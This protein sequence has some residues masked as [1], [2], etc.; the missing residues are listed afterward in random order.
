MSILEGLGLA[1]LHRVDPE[2][3]H[4]LS[5]RA[6]SAGLVPLPGVIT[7]P[8]LATTVA[9]MALPN[10]VGLA[11]GYDKNA[12]AI[13][14]LS[15]AGFGFVEVGAATPRP[16]PGNPQ[17]RLFRLTE[18][19]AAI[20]RFG[21]NNEGAEAIAA[22]LAARVRGP[23]PVGL[24]L[25]ANKDSADRAQDFARVLAVCGPHVDF[26]TVNVSS[27]N[28]EK[29]RDL[30]GRAALSALLAGVMETRAALANPIPVFLKI[31][32]DLTADEL[33]EIAEVALASGLA[34]IIATN[35]TLSREGLLSANKSQT[36]GLSGAPL[37]EKSTR[38]LAQLSQLTAGKLPLIGVGGISSAEEAYVKI[39]VGASAVQFYTAMVYQGI[40][41]AAKI[42]RG[43]DA[44][45]QRD[46][47]ANVAEAVGKGRDQWL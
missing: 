7:S 40:S 2:R 18:D 37:F 44:L 9:G 20:N 21:F 30:Q 28:T 38:V 5:L 33:A 14:A 23:V 16:Q 26:A 15:R 39:L 29:L 36:G 46:G 34:G 8:R 3:A 43:L 13:A 35:T 24:N 25:G 12:T 10:P 42:A 27:P 41:L 19:R 11:A 31:A 22:R 45:L 1:L 32:P 47:Y 17:P 6:L 4:G